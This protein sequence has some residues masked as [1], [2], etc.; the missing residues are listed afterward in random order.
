MSFVR[1][2]R[3]KRRKSGIWFAE[4]KSSWWHETKINFKTRPTIYVEVKIKPT[5]YL[6]L[7]C[8]MLHASLVERTSLYE[9]YLLTNVSDNF[10]N[11]QRVNRISFRLIL[12]WFYAWV[13]CCKIVL[14]LKLLMAKRPAALWQRTRSFT[15]QGFEEQTLNWPNRHHRIKNCCVIHA[16]QE[17]LGSSVLF[18]LKS[19]VY[20]KGKALHLWCVIGYPSFVNFLLF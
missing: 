2:R 12:H 8:T 17:N 6:Q 16:F 20:K 1:G 13:E 5:V 3:E 14:P 11:W 4:R 15:G 19:L 9:K 10:A 7:Y 18:P